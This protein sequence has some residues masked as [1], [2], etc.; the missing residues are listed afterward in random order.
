MP[1]LLFFNITNMSFLHTIYENKTLMKILKITVSVYRFPL[2]AELI[3]PQGFK[4]FFILNSADYEIYP[5]HKC[6]NANN[7]CHF[8]IYQRDKYN[9]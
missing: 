3:W 7:C 1:Q 5:A 4:T 8:N 2:N 9:I 6:Y